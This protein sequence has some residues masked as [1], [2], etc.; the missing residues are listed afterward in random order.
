[1]KLK[2]K[3]PKCADEVTLQQRLRRVVVVEELG[4][5][6]VSRWIESGWRKLPIDVQVI[7]EGEDDGG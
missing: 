3:Q 7:Y 4:G 1:M 2:P 5:V 6:T